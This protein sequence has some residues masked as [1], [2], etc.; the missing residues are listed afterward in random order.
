MV[1]ISFVIVYL[2]CRVDGCNL[3]VQVGDSFTAPALEWYKDSD[4]ISDP[5]V[6][7]GGLDGVDVDTKFEWLSD[8]GPVV[9]ENLRNIAKIESA[10]AAFW[11]LP[12]LPKVSK[13]GL[14]LFSFSPRQLAMSIYLRKYEN[15]TWNDEAIAYINAVG[16]NHIARIQSVYGRYYVFE[17][18]NLTFMGV[19]RPP[20]A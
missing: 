20:T 13:L 19:C 6:S 9:R 16:S 8:A 15:I 2:T 14:R 18:P 1:M 12:L 11:H 7:S 10:L 4:E 5:A 3:L 17:F